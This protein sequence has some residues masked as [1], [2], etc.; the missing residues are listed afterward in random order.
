MKKSYHIGIWSVVVFLLLVGGLFTFA[1]YSSSRVE[2]VNEASTEIEQNWLP[3]TRLLG[4]MEADAL[5]HRVAAMQHVLSLEVPEMRRYEADMDSAL[6][7]M[8]R[9]RQ[10]YEPLIVS[11]EEQQL[12][13]A[14]AAAW[15][16]YLAESQASLALS[17]ENQNQE[18][19]ALLRQ[20][21]QSLFDE[22]N[23]D[24]EAL[25]LLNVETAN[26]LSRQ[27]DSILGEFQLAL[28][29]FSILG[30]ALFLLICMDVIG[31][32]FRKRSLP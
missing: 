11:A 17:R 29:V 30:G 13:T 16:R 19:I 27:G 7:S 1:L 5:A 4:R 28:V 23:S 24:L 15:E 26:A 9:S 18:A 10:R 2:Q 22:A 31:K 21:S 32:N 8:T 25:I 14:F 3:S 12:Y 6:A 20:D